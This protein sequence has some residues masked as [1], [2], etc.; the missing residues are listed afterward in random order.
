M[1][2]LR[3]GKRQDQCHNARWKVLEQEPEEAVCQPHWPSDIGN[4]VKATATASDRLLRL[5]DFRLWALETM[6][7]GS[8]S[9]TGFH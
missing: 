7:L 6:Q 4:I 8:V 1:R 3:L 9:L 5:L 2:E